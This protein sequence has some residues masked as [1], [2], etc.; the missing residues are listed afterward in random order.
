LNKYSD[1]LSVDVHPTTDLSPLADYNTRE[2]DMRQHDKALLVVMV[3]VWEWGTVGLD[4]AIMERNDDMP[5][6]TGLL[7]FGVSNIPFNAPG[8][9]HICFDLKAEDISLNDGMTTVFAKLAKNG[10]VEFENRVTP[11]WILDDDHHKFE[12]S[13][14]YCEVFDRLHLTPEGNCGGGGPI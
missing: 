2:V 7:L 5:P 12:G 11:V 6:D 10:I 9:Y 14:P 13:G 3:D 1:H 8:I 4:L